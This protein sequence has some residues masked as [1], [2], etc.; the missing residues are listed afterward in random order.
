MRS[1]GRSPEQLREVKIIP[2][3]QVHPKGSCLIEMGNTRVICSVSYDDSV[4]PFLRGKG[5]GWLT[6]E[7]SMIP[8]STSSRIHRERSKLGGRTQ[9]IQRLIGRSLRNCL[10]FE[11]L[12]ERSFTVDCDV[13]DADGGT[14]TAAIT[15]SYVALALAVRA[16]EKQYPAFP[17]NVLKTPV[18]AVSVG[19]VEQVPMLDLH[20]DDDSRADVDMN[21][22]KTGE[23]AYVEVQG[24]GET[25]PFQRKQ[26]DELLALADAG[27]EQLLSIQRAVLES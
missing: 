1:D 4:P 16:L 3:F 13:L 27:I 2:N 18:A 22:V 8:G 17:K 7:Y 14:R 20:F 15:G 19:L 21:V 23:G 11:A 10:N 12:G 24:I 6:A 25:G 5:R 9:E 26:L